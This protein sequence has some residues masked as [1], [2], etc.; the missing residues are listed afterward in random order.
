MN[1]ASARLYVGDAVDFLSIG[2]RDKHVFRARII[3]FYGK[4]NLPRMAIV[5]DTTGRNARPVAVHRLR[6]IA[7]AE[8]FEGNAA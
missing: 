8:L 2:H 5:E 3:G 1:G 7:H 6:R 4:P